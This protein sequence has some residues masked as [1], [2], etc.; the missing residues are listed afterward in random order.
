LVNSTLIDKEYRVVDVF[1]KKIIEGRIASVNGSVNT[2][3]WSSGL[4]FFKVQDGPSFKV[5]KP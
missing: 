4:Y 3:N 2:E 5:V 1:G